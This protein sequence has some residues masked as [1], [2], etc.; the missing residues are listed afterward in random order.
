MDCE[1][2]SFEFILV[3]FY[4][5]E[6]VVENMRILFFVLVVIFFY[7]DVVLISRNS[8]FS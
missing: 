4:C 5:F 3:Y 7:W 2:K 1:I 6:F 8:K